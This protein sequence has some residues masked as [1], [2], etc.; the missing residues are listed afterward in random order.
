MKPKNKPQVK[1][2][3]TRIHP[4]KVVN[5]VT[6]ISVTFQVKNSEMIRPK[7]TQSRTNTKRNHFQHMRVEMPTIDNA[8]DEIDSEESMLIERYY[9]LSSQNNRFE[10]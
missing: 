2:S 9:N 6:D 8:I 4:L 10:G 1:Q 3:K 7:K 5:F